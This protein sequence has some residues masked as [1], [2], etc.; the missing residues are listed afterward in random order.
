MFACDHF[1]RVDSARLL[2]IISHLSIFSLIN[3]SAMISVFSALLLCAATLEPTWAGFRGDGT[4]VAA[5]DNLPLT[6]SDERNIAWQTPLDGYGQSSPVVLG[7]RIFLTSIEGKSK[8]VGVVACFDLKTGKKLWRAEVAA[9]Q[10]VPDSDMVSRGAPTPCA[11]AER[12][13]AF[14]E[15]GDLAAFDHAGKQHWLR[16]LVKEYGEYQGNHG[17][18]GSPAQSADALY[19]LVDHDGPSYL[20]CVDKATGKNRW[21]VDRKSKISWSSPVYVAG[22]TPLVV[23]SSNGSVEAYAAADGKLVWSLDKLEGNTVASPALSDELIVIGS[24]DV[25]ETTAL[26]RAVTASASAAQP[27]VLWKLRGAS[28][29]FS[30]PLVYRGQVYVVNKS[31][32]AAAA[33][34][35][36][37]EILWTER[38]PGSCWATAIGS[39]ERVYFFGK[40][41]VTTVVAVGPQFERLAENSLSIE[42]RI[43]GAAAVPGAIVLRTGRKLLCVGQP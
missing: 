33:K 43:Y 24:S 8:G 17:L 26:R 3:G 37:G 13:Y 18:G 12:V 25:G 35:A 31:G 16:S 41:G 1:S 11:D 19:L 20:L 28:A 40:D 34:A 42:G 38:L 39:G 14:F 29:S 21:K 10:L 4:N 15:S 30:S 7:G 6:W 36:D 23:V 2:S 22:P 27:E 5:V 9:S 32:V